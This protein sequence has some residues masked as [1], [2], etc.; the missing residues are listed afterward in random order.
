MGDQGIELHAKPLHRLITQL[1]LRTEE[2]ACQL[3]QSAALPVSPA[4]TGGSHTCAWSGLLP[5]QKPKLC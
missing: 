1:F 4:F 2:G 3:R 5:V